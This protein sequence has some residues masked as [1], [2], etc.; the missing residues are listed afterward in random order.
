MQHISTLTTPPLPASSEQTSVNEKLNASTSQS[1]CDAETIRILW[2]K[3]AAIYGHKW[4]SSFGESDDGTWLRVMTGIT[5]E[6]IAAGLRACLTR[7]DVWPPGAAEFR[8]LC[9]P[10]RR[11]PIHREYK[12]LPKPPPN[13]ALVEQSL[14]AM[15]SALNAK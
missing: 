6:Q 12:S 5:R 13:P 2:E 14:T 7:E 11:D 8:R 9:L 3:M 15:R 10:P 1:T 4:V